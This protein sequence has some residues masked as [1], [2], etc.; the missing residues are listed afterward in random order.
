MA[1]KWHISGYIVDASPEPERA[2]IDYFERQEALRKQ[3]LLRSLEDSAAQAPQ[4]K[5]VDLADF[6]TRVHLAGM[7]I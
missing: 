1:H 2:P 3:A 5:F 4:T 6:K 7:L